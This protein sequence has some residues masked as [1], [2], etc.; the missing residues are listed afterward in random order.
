M[1]IHDS[2]NMLPTEG[3]GNRHSRDHL[4]LRIPR[5]VGLNPPPALA[6]RS[7]WIHTNIQCAECN[8][9]NIVGYRYFCTTCAVSFCETC[10]QKGYPL[11]TQRTAHD[12]SH[13]LLKMVP[14]L[15][16]SNAAATGTAP[17]R[18]K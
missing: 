1:D 7:Y 13:N 5:N 2:G 12:I 10:E 18:R 15:A 17:N 3:F 8:V 14:P 4:F 9:M 6:N 16:A 11:T